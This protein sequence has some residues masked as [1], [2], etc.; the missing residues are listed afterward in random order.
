MAQAQ[1]LFI[2][3]MEIGASNIALIVARYNKDRSNSIE[4]IHS[5]VKPTQ[6]IE[7]GQIVNFSEVQKV[8]ANLLMNKKIPREVNATTRICT[9]INGL[10]FRTETH[11]AEI[12]TEYATITEAHTERLREKVRGRLTSQAQEN[13]VEIAPKRYLVGHRTTTQ[14]LGESGDVL[15]ASYLVTLASRSACEKYRSVVGRGIS[16]FYPIASSKG[17]ILLTPEHRENGVALIDFGATTTCVAVFDKGMLLHEVSIPMGSDLI[18][19][20]IAKA[21]E[22]SRS[23]AETLKRAYG[24]L[25]NETE[26]SQSILPTF[27]DGQKCEKSFLLNDLKFYARARV[28]EIVAYVNH[29]LRKSDIDDRVKKIVI[30]G[31]GAKLRGLKEMLEAKFEV[32]VEMARCND[33]DLQLSGAVG[34]AA[35]FVRDNRREFVQTQDQQGTLFGE[36]GENSTPSPAPTPAPQSKPKKDRFALFGQA[37]SALINIIDGN[38]GPSFD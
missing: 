31:G 2:V 20:D 36:F 3:A 21:L 11:D 29:A 19:R 35:R 4:V 26:D 9:S 30:T 32:N 18:T 5:E 22:I 12:V 17:L 16:Q 28:E 24:I 1:E 27:G 34:M 7:R 38:E 15:S 25:P 8:A 10:D 6:G 33:Y 14:P 13:V 23:H 37:K